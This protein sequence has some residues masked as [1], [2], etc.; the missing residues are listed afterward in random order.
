MR[1]WEEKGMK[2]TTVKS[3]GKELAA[4]LI[5]QK[6][7]LIKDVN[8]A[9]G[10]NWSEDLF[11]IL[12]NDQIAQINS[13]Y[14]QEGNKGIKE[15]NQMALENVSFAP[16]YRHPDKI[17][18]VGM[19]YIEKAVELSGKLPEEEPVIFMKPNSSLI[20]PEDVITL[21]SQSTKVTAEAELAIIIGKACKNVQE[22]D[23][24]DVIAGFTT[25]LDITAKDIHAKNPRFL[26]RS[27]SFDTFFSFGPY[28][29]TLDEVKDVKRISVETVLN[30]EVHHRNVV[31]NMMYQPWWIVSFFSQI[32]TLHPGD[33]IM[34]G[35]PG[36]VV[37]RDGDVVDCTIEGLGELRNSVSS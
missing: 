20:G 12:Q 30:G 5:D 16:L 32:M 26:Q 21:P 25:S 35:T 4:I 36:S 13:W 24:P 7:I 15:I 37:I 6:I 18:G 27:K 9:V 31:L 22:V 10:E 34:T 23:V 2:L 1:F 8:K 3:G 33:V 14:K 28:L 29:T 11:S 19:N 17:W